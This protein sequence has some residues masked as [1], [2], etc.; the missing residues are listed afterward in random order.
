VDTG[1][2]ATSTFN[3][4]GAEVA[5]NLG[6]L[7]IQSEAMYARVGQVAG[8]D[9]DFAGF[10]VQTSY[11]LT[12]EHRPYDRTVGAFDRVKPFEDFFRVRTCRGI[13]AGS[14]AWELAVRWSYVDLN[15]NNIQGGQLNDATL[16]LNWYLNPYLKIQFNY[17]RAML[18]H[19][20]LGANAADIFAL[21]TQVDF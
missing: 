16:G 19:P 15:D 2:I 5:L 20:T 6:P 3:K 11:F 4:L 12:G 8:P 21:R 1:N 13:G 18:D 10:Y 14:G 17:I 7:A 9:L